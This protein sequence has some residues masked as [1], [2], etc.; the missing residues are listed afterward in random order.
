MVQ[1]TNLAETTTRCLG[2]TPQRC[3]GI[4]QLNV[5]DAWKDLSVYG[6]IALM[7]MGGTWKK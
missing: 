7:V 3:W 6:I 4:T 5:E 2:Y 1:Y